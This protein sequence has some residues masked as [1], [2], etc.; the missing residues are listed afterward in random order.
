MTSY[1]DL[2]F[3]PEVEAE[4]ARI[5][6]KGKFDRR[7]AAKQ[8]EPMLEREQE[9][10]AS[11]TTLY[12][13][14]NSSSGWPY[15]QH[16]G[17]PAGFLKVL[18][19]FTIGFA[20]YFGNRQLITKG[21]L[22]TDDRVSVFAMDYARQ[23]RLKL[24]GHATLVNADEAPEL[25]DAFAIQG[26]GRVERIMTIRIAAWDWNCPK[27]ITPRFDTAEMTALV[28]PELSR[29]ETRTAELEAE[30]ASLR[31]QLKEQK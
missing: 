10:L 21:N 15:V 22:T 27:Y 28:G 1:A 24:Q 6:A 3:T 2:L 18:D 29:L 23:A 31:A 17:G 20:D 12:I 13:A 19:P 16:R 26:Q 11:R 8:D 30:V 4:Q 7:Y 5:G 14:S 25:T 9:F